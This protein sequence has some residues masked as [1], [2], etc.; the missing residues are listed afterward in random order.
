MN[1]RANGPVGMRDA[2]GIER[3][4]SARQIVIELE[5]GCLQCRP[6]E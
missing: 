1:R 2:L 5:P 6:Y 4:I 3:G